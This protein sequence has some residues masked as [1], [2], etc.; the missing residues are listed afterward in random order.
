VKFAGV[1]QK[2]ESLRRS[3]S[4]PKQLTT[5]NF[6]LSDAA[7]AQ[8]K[9]GRPLSCLGLLQIASPMAAQRLLTQ[10]V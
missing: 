4:F 6:A 8:V 5:G 2:T 10:K 1:S 9:V 7:C 3:I